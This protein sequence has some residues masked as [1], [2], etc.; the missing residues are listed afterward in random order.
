[1]I[2]SM[3]SN[4]KL[5][6]MLTEL[7]IRGGKLNTSLFLLN[8]FIFLYQKMLDW[9]S[10]QYLIVKIPNERELQQIAFNH[11]SDIDFCKNAN[12]YW[13]MYCEIIYPAGKRCLWEISIKYPLRETSQRRLRNVSQEISFFDVF[14]TSQILLGKDV[15]Y[16]TSLR[17]LK[18]IFKKKSFVWRL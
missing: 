7:F 13:K 17:H 8:N 12:F 6:P 18:N 16:V 4:K 9:N 2:S 11:S 15:F 10:T 5:N 1:M 3:L 14:K